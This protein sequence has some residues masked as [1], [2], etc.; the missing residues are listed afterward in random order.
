MSTYR[1]SKKKFRRS[2]R[3]WVWMLVILIVVIL[4][5]AVL[6]LGGGLINFFERHADV[7]DNQY[8]STGL[9]RQTTETLKKQFK[10]I[11]PNKLEQLK[12]KFL[13]KQSKPQ[14]KQ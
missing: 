8:I 11:D 5:G 4:V 1:R 2:R 10:D 6:G 3:S 12:R 7:L 14:D 13:D 9:D